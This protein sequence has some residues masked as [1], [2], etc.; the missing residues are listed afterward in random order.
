M[1]LYLVCSRGP[2]AP[3]GDSNAFT[4]QV[5]EMGSTKGVMVTYVRDP[6][7]FQVSPGVRKPTIWI[8]TRSDVNQAVQPLKMARS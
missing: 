4:K 2:R 1:I 5:V 8:L 3:S 7:H 6:G